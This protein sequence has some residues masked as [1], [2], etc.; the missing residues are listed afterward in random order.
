MT[1][2]QSFS[3]GRPAAL[4]ICKSVSLLAIVLL[5]ATTSTST[6]PLPPSP[7]RHPPCPQRSSVTC[8]GSLNFLILLYLLW[9]LP[10]YGNGNPKAVLGVQA[11]KI[12]DSGTKNIRRTKGI[13][14]LKLSTRTFWVRI[15]YC[16]PYLNPK[17]MYN[18]SPEALIVAI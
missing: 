2:H 10:T 6:S 14:G 7:P 8:P 15:I 3:G 17:S 4:D 12:L 9:I 13:W 16:K 1:Y 18:N 11:R 5:L